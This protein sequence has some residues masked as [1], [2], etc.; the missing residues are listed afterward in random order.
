MPPLVK[1]VMNSKLFLNLPSKISLL[2]MS[3]SSPTARDVTIRDI[4]RP[5]SL[6]HHSPEKIDLATS[7]KNFC[8]P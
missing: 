3:K 2:I 1:N 6:L 7:A 5:S 4:F 8:I